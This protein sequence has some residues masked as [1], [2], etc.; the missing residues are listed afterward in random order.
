MTRLFTEKKLVIATHN[1]GKL[2][3]FRALLA[4]YGVTLTSSGELGLPEPEE[5]G[6]TFRENALIKARAAMRATGLPALA[7]DSGLCVNALHGDP[8]LFSARWAGP[9]RDFLFAMRRVH[10]ALGTNADRSA[11]F[12]CLL[13]L[14][15]PDDHAEIVE[16]RCDGEIAWPPRG[17]KGHGYDPVFQPQGE[18]RTFAEMEGDEKNAISH[19]G[20]ALAAL[21]KLFAVA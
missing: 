19:R 13:A 11:F 17:T 18:T 16:G 20:R 21:T 14:V 15:W 4:P 1:N 6:A 7:D 8:G 9:D 2:V 5:T 10:E 3:E 12:I